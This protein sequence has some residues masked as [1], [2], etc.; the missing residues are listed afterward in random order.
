MNL[1]DLDKLSKKYQ[2]SSSEL[3]ACLLYI[4]TNN[5][6]WSYAET[7]AKQ[8]KIK[9]MQQSSTNFF[10]RH[11][12]NHFIMQERAAFLNS[13]KDGFDDEE[14]DNKKVQKRNTDIFIQSG[15]DSIELTRENIKSVMENE[16]SKTKDPEKRTALLIK[17]ADFLSLNNNVSE[18]IERPV[19][20]LPDRNQTTT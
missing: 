11:D 7:I 17:I 14:Q 5:K 13:F 15:P 1:N 20:Y 10:A 2:I 18:D 6:T 19:I 9:Y 8:K 4:Q 3:A 12:I 16:L